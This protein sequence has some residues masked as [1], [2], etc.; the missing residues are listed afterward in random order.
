MSKPEGPPAG[1][2]AAV[3]GAVTVAA[4]TAD[5][6]LDATRRLLE[7]LIA[8][9]GLEP[10]RIVSAI[11][12]ATPDLDADFPAHAARRMGWL[13]VPLLGAREMAVPG[14][15]PRVIRV[16]LTVWGVPP[17]ARL[18]PV[19]LDGAAALRPDLAPPPGRSETAASPRRVA[20]IGVGQ[21]GGSIGLALA[22]K[23]SWHRVGWDRDASVLDRALARGAID[24]RAESLA[25]ACRNAELAV[26]AAPVDALP[27]LVDQ[28]AAALPPGAALI[29]TGSARAGITAALARA[30]ARGVH[31]IGAHPIAGTEGRGIASARADLFEGGS[32]A[33]LPG[34]AGVPEAVTALVRDLGGTP[35]EV[36]PEAHDRALARTSHLPYLLACALDEVGGVH[37]GA[38]L[39]GPGFR[40]MTRLAASDPRMALAYCRANARELADAWRELERAMRKRLAELR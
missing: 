28:A 21:I 1:G 24:E 22:G 36:D 8:A 25:A 29:D 7:A 18:T 3:R 16:L 17:G 26:L 39:A 2:I 14:A 38:G 31:A 10:D 40:D 30:S 27:D 12:T 37:A 13:D 9:N 5:D 15:M 11:F 20:I 34:G 19:Y 33:L 32:F 23:A 6:V 35:I 4:N